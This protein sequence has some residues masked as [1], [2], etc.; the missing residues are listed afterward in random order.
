MFCIVSDTY[1]IPVVCIV[2]HSFPI[3]SECEQ[4][5]LSPPY[6]YII[7]KK[8][9]EKIYELILLSLCSLC[10]PR[11]DFGQEE[12]ARFGELC[13]GENGK[14]REWFAKYVSAQV[15]IAPSEQNKPEK[16][17]RQCSPAWCFS[18]NVFLCQNF[19]LNDSCYKAENINNA[20]VF[21]GDL[22]VFIKIKWLLIFCIMLNN[23]VWS[24]R[25][26][27]YL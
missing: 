2:L 18:L 13:S 22:F 4:C 25:F 15:N 27:R 9:I 24:G 11:E 6:T 21:N 23:F 19:P 7:K 14:G 1:Y 10:L 26:V 16:W 17:W 5:V 3:S 12:K 8:F 20:Y